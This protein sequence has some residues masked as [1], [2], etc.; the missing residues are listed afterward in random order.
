MTASERRSAWD[1]KSAGPLSRTAIDGSREKPSRRTS[2]P[3]REASIMVWT[4]GER[5]MAAPV[6]RARARRYAPPRAAGRGPDQRRTI[7]TRR[8]TAVSVIWQARINRTVATARS[9]RS[10]S[11]MAP[12]K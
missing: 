3:A 9:G 1:T 4:S 10:P 11:P 7:P 2:A 12:A 5:M 8:V 6:A